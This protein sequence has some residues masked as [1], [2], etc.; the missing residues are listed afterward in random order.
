MQGYDLDVLGLEIPFR[1]VISFQPLGALA[2]RFYSLDVGVHARVVVGDADVSDS[3]AT[4][5]LAVSGILIGTLIGKSFS[6][7]ISLIGGPINGAYSK[8]SAR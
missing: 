8:S 4:V 1:R 2:I 3:P 5:E 6:L 7:V